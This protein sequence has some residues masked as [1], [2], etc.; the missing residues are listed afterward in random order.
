M[1]PPSIFTGIFRQWT[2]TIATL[3]KP[4]SHPKQGKQMWV[5]RAVITK[6]GHPP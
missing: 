6:T 5:S 2:T 3:L 1:N 4:D